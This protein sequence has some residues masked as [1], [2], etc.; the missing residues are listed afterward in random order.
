[1]V[2]FTPGEADAVHYTGYL[3]NSTIV[4]AYAEEIGGATIV[5]EREYSRSRM[6]C[7]LSQLSGKC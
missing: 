4:G 1:V 5:L 3:T 2:L 6:D 7:K